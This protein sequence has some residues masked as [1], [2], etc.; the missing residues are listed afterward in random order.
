MLDGYDLHTHVAPL[1]LLHRRV[2]YVPTRPLPNLRWAAGCFEDLVNN[3][4]EQLRDEVAEEERRRA[5]LAGPAP[6]GT[7]AEEGGGEGAEQQ[8]NNGEAK[9]ELEYARGPD[10]FGC[11][12]TGF[13]NMTGKKPRGWGKCVQYSGLILIDEMRGLLEARSLAHA[14]PFP[15]TCVRIPG[16]LASLL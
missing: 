1:L 16:V 15:Y 7:T 13:K 10:I 14:H 6:D 11:N 4:Q 12:P 3:V 9:D 8:P 2:S 5:W